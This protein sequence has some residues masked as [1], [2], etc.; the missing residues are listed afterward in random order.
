MNSNVFVKR[1]VD[2]L[3]QINLT[4]GRLNL[5]QELNTAP[6]SPIGQV[7]DFVTTKGLFILAHNLQQPPLRE[8]QTSLHVSVGV[9]NLNLGSCYAS[10]P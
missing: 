8:A 7:F 2:V 6:F 5:D 9:V 10:V 3:I 4:G 1:G